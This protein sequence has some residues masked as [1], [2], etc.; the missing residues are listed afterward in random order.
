M[1]FALALRSHDMKR[2]LVMR[3]RGSGW[4]PPFLFMSPAERRRADLFW[5]ELV[6]AGGRVPDGIVEVH[7]A[8]GSFGEGDD[9]R[10]WSTMSILPDSIVDQIAANRARVPS[11][12]GELRPFQGGAGYSALGKNIPPSVLCTPQEDQNPR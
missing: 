2:S 5:A 4:V 3:S 11:R 8:E 10:S 6:G 12:A 1:P 9:L 7:D